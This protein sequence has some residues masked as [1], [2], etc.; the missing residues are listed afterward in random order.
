MVTIGMNYRVLEG[1]EAVFE[2]AFKSVLDVIVGIEGH[3]E[4][5]LYREVDDGGTYLIVSE[6]ADEAAF[7][8]FIRSEQFERVTNWGKDQVLSGPPKHQVYS[9]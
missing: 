2:R 6:W 9:S 1:K 4:S 8:D 3:L 5:H 7:T